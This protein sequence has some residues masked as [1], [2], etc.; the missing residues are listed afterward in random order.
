MVSNIN[1]G[2]PG[3]S[4]KQVDCS[5]YLTQP[6]LKSDE[7]FNNREVKIPR[8]KVSLLNNTSEVDERCLCNVFE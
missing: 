5:P 7:I 6:H 3:S 2:G 8:I 4:F 1:M